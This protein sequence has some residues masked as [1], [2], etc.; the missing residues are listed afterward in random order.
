MR[1]LVVLEHTKEAGLSAFTEVLDARTSQSPWR[2]IH[3]PDG[4]ALPDDLDAV[5]GLI[6]MGGAMSAVDPQAH[7][8]MPPE[9]DLLRRA[10]AADVPVLG[11]CLGAQLLG[12]A[13]GGEVAA[14]AVPQVGFVPLHQSPEV[15]ND[16]LFAGWPD[17][18]P[19]LFVHEDEVRTLPPGAVAML[20]G[21][22]GVAA[23]RVGH[24]WGVQFHPEVTPAQLT[25]WVS[26]HLLDELLSRSGIATEALLAEAER[27]GRFTVPQGRALVGRFLDGPVRERLAG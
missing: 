2:R 4:D 19:A 11:V 3:V 8:W 20:L 25:S 21:S 22:E 1:E 26:D 16:E 6:V 5:A 17:G 18:A 15:S 13:L 7:P 12:S 10:V 9:L 14:R 23:W 24:A 27:R